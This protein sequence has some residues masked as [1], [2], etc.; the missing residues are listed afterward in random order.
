MESEGG[1]GCRGEQMCGVKGARWWATAAEWDQVHTGREGVQRG[2]EAGRAAA[3]LLRHVCRRHDQAAAVAGKPGVL[4][5]VL[6]AQQ[7]A[8]QQLLMLSSDAH[9]LQQV[10]WG[11]E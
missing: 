10:A 6:H 11:E 9:I 4:R 1:G 2:E 7:R 5:R 3:N 8:L